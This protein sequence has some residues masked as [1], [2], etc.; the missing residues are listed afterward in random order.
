MRVQVNSSH[1]LLWYVAL[2]GLLVAALVVALSRS[3][4]DV[5]PAAS[6]ESSASTAS[7]A[8][9]PVGEP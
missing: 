6:V 7:D 4:A 2:L 3:A 8:A 5:R 1:S 9:T